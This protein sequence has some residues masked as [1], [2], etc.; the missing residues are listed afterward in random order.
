MKRYHGE[1]LP[2]L[3]LF[4]PPPLPIFEFEG[5]DD[6]GAGSQ[7]PQVTESRGN[8]DPR[9]DEESAKETKDAYTLSLVCIICLSSSDS[10]GINLIF[11]SSG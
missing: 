4:L 10:V 6:R 2:P 1:D 9:W 11:A 7:R 5:R 8:L 3:D